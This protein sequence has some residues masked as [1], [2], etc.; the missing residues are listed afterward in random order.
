MSDSTSHIS[1]PEFFELIQGS[2]N[3]DRSTVLSAI[4]SPKTS[5]VGVASGRE[6]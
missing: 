6:A 1:T 3:E 4:T 5:P 2:F